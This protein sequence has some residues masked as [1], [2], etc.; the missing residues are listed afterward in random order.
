MAEAKATQ[1]L[2]QV[3]KSFMATMMKQS[4]GDMLRIMRRE[5]L[6]LPQVVSLF[7]LRHAGSACIGDVGDHLNLSPAATS[8]LVDRLVVAGLISRTESADD[9]RQKQVDLTDRG[10]VVLAELEQARMAS[11][12]QRFEAMPP[13]LR[14]SMIE[15]L[16]KVTAFLAG[17]ESGRD[18]SRGTP[19][20]CMGGTGNN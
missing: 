4:M 7:F 14:D 12:A 3:L 6:S 17:S 16:T 15:V 9:R 19:P 10:R 8:H 18:D 11:V 5:E 20:G 2:E 1:Q 13:D